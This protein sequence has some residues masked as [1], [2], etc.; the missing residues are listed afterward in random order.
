MASIPAGAQTAASNDDTRAVMGN[1]V[2]SNIM[3]DA[4]ASLPGY[5]AATSFAVPGPI[6]TTNGPVT[7]RQSGVTWTVS[8]P[9]HALYPPAGSTFQPGGQEVNLQLA[10]GVNVLGIVVS[11]GNAGGGGED[12]SNGVGFN[13]YNKAIGLPPSGSQLGDYIAPATGGGNGP[14]NIPNLSG[15]WVCL[16]TSQITP[17]ISTQQHSFASYAYDVV[18]LGGMTAGPPTGSVTFTIDNAAG[19]PVAGYSS[20]VSTFAPQGGGLYS[21]QSANA[22]F[23]ALNLAP[24]SYTFE[25]TYT[26]GN[27]GNYTTVSD[28]NGANETFSVGAI[29]PTVQT[30]P[31]VNGHAAYDTV[32]VIGSGTTPTGYVNFTLYGANGAVVGVQYG[33]LLVGGSATSQSFTA[34]AAGN[35]YFVATYLGDGLYVS[36]AGGHEVFSVGLLVPSVNTTPQTGSSSAYDTVTVSGPPGQGTPSGMVNF[37]LYNASGGV[38]GTDNNVA[39]VGGSATSSSFTDLA[40][41]NYYFIATYLGDAIYGALAG[42][43][44]ALAIAKVTPTLATTP[45]PEGT[46]AYDTATVTGTAGTPTGTVTFTLVK[47]TYPSGTPVE[48]FGTQTVS[49]SGGSATSPKASGLSSGS[50]YFLATYGGDANYTAITVA[51]PEPFFIIAVSPPKVPKKPTKPVVPPYKI[52]TKPPTTGFGGSAHL[53][54][55]GGLLAGGASVLLA[56]LLMMAYA[57]RRR[58][59]L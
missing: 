32:S 37:T 28:I 58:R 36:V 38:V 29:T 11:G 8:T 51:T 57:L 41:G 15:F 46:S 20:T 2:S 52:P 1:D 44:E 5:N 31:Q 42:G 43:Q 24:G 54:Y 48:S 33:V 25:A 53:V 22:N 12:N 9:G 4:C 13:F 21:A 59:R 40:P 18:N 3:A 16:G 47:G 50:Y 14:G 17:T 27:A 45:K 55:N 34:L 26:H 30:T 35:Y 23:A 7:G 10:V 6:D 56:G 19:N 39:L 49:L